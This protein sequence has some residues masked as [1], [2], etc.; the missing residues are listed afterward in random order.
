MI[1]YLIYLIVLFFTLYVITNHFLIKIRNFPPTIF[2]MIP[3]IG[4]LHHLKKP[5]HRFFSHLSEK[6]GPILLLQLG[7]RRVLLVSSPSLAEECLTKNDLIFANRPNILIGKHLGYDCTSIAWA[8]YG[9][10]W[11]SLRKLSSVEIF[12]SQRLQLLSN[13]RNDEVRSMISRIY[14]NKDGIVDLNAIF[15]ELMLNVM[16]RM[17]SG[18]KYYGANVEEAEEVE[19]F[20][21]IVTETFFLANT[22]MG[23]YLPWL[24]AI[25]GEGKKFEEVR[26]KRD[27]FIQYLIDEHRKRMASDSPCQN[28]E[29][30][31]TLIPVL[32]SLQKSDPDGFYTDGTIKSLLLTLLGAGTDTSSSTM[33]W[34]MSL[35]V[36]NPEILKK[37]QNEIDTVIGHDQLMTESDV[38]RLP[39]LQCVINEVMRM[40]PATPMLLP[41]ESSEDCYVGG[42]R[43]PRG[44]MLIVN[45][46]AIQNDPKVWEEPKKFKP[47]RFV[48]FNAIKDG[49]KL[50][51]FGVGRRRCPGD[52][53]ALRIIGFSL[54]SILQCFDWERVGQEMVDMTEGF[55]LTM[56]KAEPLRVKCKPRSSMLKLLSQI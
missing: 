15:F 41:H 46:W 49:F 36:N 40:Y 50:M 26:Q 54:G 51:P 25:K 43:V 8:P 16:M 2:P 32:L 39:Y 28:D 7:H 48:G 4:H 5:L 10:L 6:Y 56:P 22:N 13:I 34:G 45:A 11:R 14:N 29:R 44:T 53:L 19:R 3:I 31:A 18:K 55:G 52:A 24:G 17:I 38:S 27:G 23:D 33:E 47:E 30:N 20:R 9:S 37:A 1:L 21:K 12:S 42:Y 35:L